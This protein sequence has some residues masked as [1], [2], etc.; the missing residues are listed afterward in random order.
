MDAFFR[1]L[2][3][4]GEWLSEPGPTVCVFCDSEWVKWINYEKWR[5]DWKLNTNDGLR[6]EVA[7]RKIKG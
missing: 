2:E 3:C 6:S 7:R 5:E 4:G 1:C